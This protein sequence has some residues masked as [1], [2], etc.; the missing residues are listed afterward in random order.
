MPKKP[1]KPRFNLAK[2][3][4]V[5]NGSQLRIQFH[6]DFEPA[7]AAPEALPAVDVPVIRKA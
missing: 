1:K 3:V 7:P 2:I 4:F 6:G 5:E